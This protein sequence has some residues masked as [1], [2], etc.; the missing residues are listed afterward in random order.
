M[1]YLTGSSD[2]NSRN[3]FH[4]SWLQM[5]VS[6]NSFFLDI[7]LLLLNWRTISYYQNTLMNSCITH[8][9]H[10]RNFVNFKME[11]M[12]DVSIRIVDYDIEAHLNTM[13]RSNM[14]TFSYVYRIY[15]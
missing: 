12:C 14:K 10:L 9:S 8:K 6:V 11:Y 3:N 4:I 7:L 1:I 13:C 5:S 2:F 15:Q